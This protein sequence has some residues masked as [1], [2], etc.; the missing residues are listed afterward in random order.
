MAPLWLHP[1]E[2]GALHTGL[3]VA[4]EVEGIGLSGRLYPVDRT[5][6]A[7][8]DSLFAEAPFDALDARPMLV[9]MVG[10]TYDAPLV[11]RIDSCTEAEVRELIARRGSVVFDDGYRRQLAAFLA[12]FFGN[13]ERRG[14][15]GPLP[16][17]APA[18]P[19]MQYTGKRDG[20]TLDEAL[21]TVRVRRIETWYH[22]G[23]FDLLDDRVVLTVPLRPAVAEGGPI[24]LLGDSITAAGDWPRLL[25]RSDVVN[26][27]IPGDT[28]DDILARLDAVRA[29][30]PRVVLLLVGVNDLASGVPL[31]R[32]AARHELIVTA[33]RAAE[34]SP[35]VVVESVLPVSEGAWNVLDNDRVR[36]LNRLLESMSS[37]LGVAYLDVTTAFAGSDRA[38]R[39]D[40][41]SDGVHLSQ[42]GYDAWA[43]ELVPALAAFPP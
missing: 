1:M 17:P 41:T 26:A 20:F 4:W 14:R 40:L 11:S 35:T 37:R 16:F 12:R 43:R 39:A 22:R 27:G 3:N 8:Y 18:L 15:K 32:I 29:L 23:R 30:R 25:G 33:L 2:F 36:A 42:A 5:F 10:T 34:P 38:I 31:P 7:P 9:G 24:V 21:A 28:T 13:L 19:T 6:M